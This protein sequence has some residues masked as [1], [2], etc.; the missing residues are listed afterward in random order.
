MDGQRDFD[1]IAIGRAEGRFRSIQLRVS[2]SPVEFYRVVVRYGNGTSDE[3]EVR[4]HI[5]AGGQTRPIDL[6]GDDRVIS[7]VDFFYGKANWR[8][9]ARPRVRLY[10]R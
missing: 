10:A 1:R 9:G 2:G 3:V 4:E 5:P 8:Y 6:R 7:S